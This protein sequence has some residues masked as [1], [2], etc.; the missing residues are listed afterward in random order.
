[1]S[2]K[3]PLFLLIKSLSKAEKRYFKLFVLKPPYKKPKYVS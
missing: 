3:Q 1:M 2:K